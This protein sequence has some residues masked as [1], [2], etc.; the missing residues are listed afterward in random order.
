MMCTLGLSANICNLLVAVSDALASSCAAKLAAV[1]AAGMPSAGLVK[2]SAMELAA[3][4]ARAN[5]CGKSPCQGVAEAKSLS[6]LS[7]E[8]LRLR[9]ELPEDDF[10][11][12][13]CLSSLCPGAS[14]ETRELSLGAIL[15]WFWACDA[16]SLL[17]KSA[18]CSV[19]CALS[20][21]MALLAAAK[22]CR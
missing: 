4:A 18:A 7:V 10:A 6:L 2:A 21:W 8:A 1:R 3:E 11:L 5:A 19:A 13:S 17:A 20:V 14:F 12:D 16:L 9:W 15:S 22:L